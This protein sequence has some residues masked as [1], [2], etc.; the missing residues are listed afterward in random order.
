[1]VSGTAVRVAVGEGVEIEGGSGG[2][3]MVCFLWHPATKTIAVR[4]SAM[5]EI[6]CVLEFNFILLESFL[7]KSRSYFRLCSGEAAAY[8]DRFATGPQNGSS[9]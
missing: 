5:V 6:R 3:D 4:A 8:P 7:I 2:G 9:G 1:M